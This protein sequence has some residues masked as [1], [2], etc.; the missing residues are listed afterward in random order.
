M[1]IFLTMKH[2]QLF[3]LLIGIPLVVELTAFGY[4]I[5]HGDS[6]FFFYFF[7][8]LLFVFMGLFFAWFYSLGTNLHKRLPA[9]APMSLTTFKLFLFIPIGYF[10]CIF[11]FVFLIPGMLPS[12][13]PLI[14]LLI[15]PIHIFSMFCLFYCLNF[16]TKAL[17]TA[18]CQRPTTFGDYAGDFYLLWF[19]PV[20]IWFI[21]PRI[22]KLFNPAPAPL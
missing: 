18:E 1:R 8:S 9:I 2:W 4:L 6:F 16:I 17:K 19:Y 13:G 7:Y 21:Q 5:I 22:N 3:V 11:L 14:F 12:L 20:G 10:I 15:V